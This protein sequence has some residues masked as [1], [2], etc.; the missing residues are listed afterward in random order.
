[1]VL[2]RVFTKRPS[3]TPTITRPKGSDAV[4]YWLNFRCH[5]N[6]G[7]SVAIVTLTALIIPIGNEIKISKEWKDLGKKDHP[8]F[9]FPFFYFGWEIP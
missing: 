5:V 4:N 9:P 2:N 7:L 3:T 8:C 1:M 6:S